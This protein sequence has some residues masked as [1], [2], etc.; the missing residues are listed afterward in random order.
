VQRLK[1]S[2]T[3]RGQSLWEA[4]I[5]H[6]NDH[7]MISRR[8]VLDRFHRDDEALV[9]GVLRDLVESGLVFSSDTAKDAVFRA[10]SADELSSMQRAR[11]P[12]GV[13][14]LVWAM[15]FHEGP[16]RRDQLAA[17][18][19]LAQDALDP[20]LQRLAAESKVQRHTGADGTYYQA[21]TLV[22]E[23]DAQKGWEAS[24]YDHFHALAQTICCRL[25]PDPEIERFESLTGGST[26]T[27]CVGPDHPLERE[28]LNTLSEFRDCCT[29]LRRR[30]VDRNRRHGLPRPNE[31]VIV[32]AGEC[33]IP[34]E[35]EAKT[36]AD[37]A[38]VTEAI[39]KE[40]LSD[41]RKR[42]GV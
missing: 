28:V 1:E 36:D 22:V 33:V 18:L 12:Q 39:T 20:A 32:Y 9:R 30:V 19:N 24:V 31:T 29:E 7:P 3:E 26:Y 21:T 40:E 8:E 27:F 17:R 14:E 11:G 25:N 35:S 16:I 23:R 13:D 15:V 4:V 37:D 10:T 42:Q 38:N 2:S 41:E 34:G 6:V 5:N